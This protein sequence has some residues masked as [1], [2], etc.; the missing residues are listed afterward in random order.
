MLSS[1]GGPG[2]GASVGAV[3]GERGRGDV[4]AGEAAEGPEH[5][6][7]GPA[8]RDQQVAQ[9]GAVVERG[10]AIFT[11]SVV[12]AKADRKDSLASF[13]RPRAIRTRP[14]LLDSQARPSR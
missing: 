8:Q 9:G 10:G 13:D 4:V 5:V 14:R 11:R 3:E 1:A 2:A 6:V 12:S 7:L